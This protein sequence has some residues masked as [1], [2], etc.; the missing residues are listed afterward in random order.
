MADRTSFAEEIAARYAQAVYR[1]IVGDFPNLQSRTLELLI[2]EQVARQA[3]APSP[4]FEVIIDEPV[5]ANWRLVPEMTGRG[6][7]RV[8]VAC[9]KPRPSHANA[10]RE[11]RLNAALRDIQPWTPTGTSE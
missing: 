7:W 6:R 4:A 1:V 5:V 9:C 8:Q 10:R 2:L 11:Q 3:E